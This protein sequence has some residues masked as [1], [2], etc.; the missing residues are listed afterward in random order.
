MD[1]SLKDLQD[2][3]EYEF[4]DSGLLM[5]ALTH[6]SCGLSYNYE[7]LEFLGDAVLE[8]VISDLLYKNNNDFNEGTLT[9]K[10]SEIVCA[11][12]LAGVARGIGLG[13]Y[14]YLGKGEEQSGGRGKQSIL[15]NAMEAMIGAIYLDGGFYA[16]QAAVGR[17]FFNAVKRAASAQ[18][19]SD[20]KSQL[21]EMVQRTVKQDI[22]YLVSRQEGPPH[23]TTFYVRLII[24]PDVICEGVGSSKKEAEQ[25]AA[26][27]AIE[28]FD[29]INK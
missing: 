1:E 15:E 23:N 4:I 2:K 11:K 18:H 6:P 14:L 21:Q 27:Y 20:Y 13:E 25:N 22:H 29:R 9:Q 12:S 28:N 10:R 19:D 3:I 7:R 24:G 26:K 17:L 5:K 16:A 8:L